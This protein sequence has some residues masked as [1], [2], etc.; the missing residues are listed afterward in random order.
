MNAAGK[1]FSFWTD[2]IAERSA[3]G[4][5]SSLSRLMSSGQL[6]IGTRLP[7]VRAL[8]AALNVS[9]TTVSQAWQSLSRRGVIE[10]RGRSG[11]KVAER[12][13]G[14][15]RWRSSEFGP[16]RTDHLNLSSGVPDGDL[17]PDLSLALASMKQSLPVSNYQEPPVLP[18]LEQL[19]RRRWP[20]EVEDLS[21]TD[22]ALDA[23]DRS[24]TELIRF[25]DRVL[26]EDPTYP[27]ILD[28]IEACGGTAVGMP[29]DQFGILTSYVAD[30]I[31]KFSP[32]ALIVQPRAQNP[33]GIT[34]SRTMAGSGVRRIGSVCG[35]RI[36][37]QAIRVRQRT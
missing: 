37:T 9:P 19:L 15:T 25:G 23:L 16:P 14:G 20:Y 33:T 4:I 13:R 36:A 35:W 29:M 6:P 31:Q 8:A 34:M 11:T 1:P 28:L 10:S 18:A 30:A 21:L 7:T 27:P 2:N 17:L 3:V 24:L 32:V 12:K 22:G 26:V 5:A